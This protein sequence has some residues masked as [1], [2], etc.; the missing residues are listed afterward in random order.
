[1][2]RQ[3]DEHDIALM[4]LHRAIRCYIQRGNVAAKAKFPRERV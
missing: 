3:A 1:M 4:R 2:Q